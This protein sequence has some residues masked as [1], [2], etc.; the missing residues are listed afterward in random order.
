MAE[1]AYL[2]F[3]GCMIPLRHPQIELAARKSMENLGVS[4]RESSEFTCCP[5]PWNMKASSLEKWLLIAARNLAVAEKEGS[6]LL[7]LC[8]G[9]FSTLTE[10]SHLLAQNKGGI[11][12]KV[13]KDLSSMGFSYSGKTSVHHVA[14]VLCGMEEKRVLASAKKELGGLKVALHHGCHLLRPSE[15]LGFDDPFEP[16]LL[17]EFVRRLGAE[18]V[19]YRGYTDCCGRA[20]LN[21]DASLE[22]AEQ[23][24][25]AMEKEDADCVVVAC[26]ACFEQFDLGQVEISRRLGKNHQLPVIHICQ[27]LALA[28]GEPPESLG[29][30]R[31]KIAIKPLLAKI[32]E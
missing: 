1:D 17:E 12:E 25:S 23:K 9:C 32:G 13:V 8:N 18:P 7:T 26:P 15:I 11:K 3:L 19:A 20:T 5:E 2:L 21:R 27:L 16:R 24:L 30:E 31:H 28:Q 22:M 10:A 6:Q 4:L 14:Q 29:L